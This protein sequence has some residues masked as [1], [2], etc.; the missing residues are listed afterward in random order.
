M[1]PTPPPLF[2][3]TPTMYFFRVFLRAP[4]P[5]PPVVFK[6]E[7]LS[8]PSSH[9]RSWYSHLIERSEGYPPPHGGSPLSTGEHP[10]PHHPRFLFALPQVICV[11][12]SISP[13]LRPCSCMG[14][15]RK[16]RLIINRVCR[17]DIDTL[18]PFPSV[19]IFFF[20]SPLNPVP[21]HYGF[22]LSLSNFAAPPTGFGTVSP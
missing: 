13:P 18:C 4:P 15:Q 10:P 16:V 2:V 21:I 14:F 3:N 22:P 17:P 7:K 20:L 12:I 9:R 8:V 19:C 1:S 6:S 5:H 11:I